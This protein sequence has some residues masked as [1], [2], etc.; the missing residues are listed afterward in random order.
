MKSCNNGIFEQA[1]N[2]WAIHIIISLKL[3]L[4]ECFLRTIT[5][6]RLVEIWKC[7]R[8]AESKIFVLNI[9]VSKRLHPLLVS[10]MQ[11]AGARSMLLKFFS[12]MYVQSVVFC[13]NGRLYRRTQLRYRG[14]TALYFLHSGIPNAKDSQRASV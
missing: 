13:G 5:S 1:T 9:S 6:F 8:R 4:L 12:C 11:F 14:I 3:S 10:I 7:S 2:K